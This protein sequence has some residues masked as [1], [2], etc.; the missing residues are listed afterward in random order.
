MERIKEVKIL[1]SDLTSKEITMNKKRIE[2]SILVISNKR[3]RLRKN[4]KKQIRDFN[5]KVLI[6]K[7]KMQEQIKRQ[8][9]D[10]VF[11]TDKEHTKLVNEFKKKILIN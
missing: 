2:R 6:G 9:M 7:E 10:N 4:I 1:T 11:L 3:M 5:K 8:H